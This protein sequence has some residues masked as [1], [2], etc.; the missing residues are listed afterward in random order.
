MKTY[1]MPSQYKSMHEVS[2]KSDNGKGFTNMGEI[3]ERNQLNG[4]EK[5]RYVPTPENG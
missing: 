1:K 5:P 2:S 3:R 4:V